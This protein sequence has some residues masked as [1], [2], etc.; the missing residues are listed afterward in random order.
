MFFEHREYRIKDGQ[1][2]RMVKLMEEEIIP[3][4]VSKGVVVVGSFVAMDDPDLYVWIRRF[5]SEEE[6]ERLYKEVYD[7]DVWKNEI[8]PQVGEMMDRETIRVTRLEATPRSV[9]R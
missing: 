7:S 9:I 3:F 2:D 8:G 1:R 6:A 4:Q 5:D